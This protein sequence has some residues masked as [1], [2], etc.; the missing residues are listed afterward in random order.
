MPGVTELMAQWG[1][2]GLLIYI[3]LKDIL[4]LIT[5]KWIPAKIQEAEDERRARVQELEDERRWKKEIDMERLQELKQIA[6]STTALTLSMTQ[7]NERVANML[8]NDQTIMSKQDSH[9]Q[10]M[11]DAVGD[12]REVVARDFPVKGD[13]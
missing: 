2:L 11:M 7:M 8:V 3:L 4:P 5:K 9:H 10:A 1:W 6:Q 12:M 13:K